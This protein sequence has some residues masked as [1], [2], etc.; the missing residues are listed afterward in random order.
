[1]YFSIP[2]EL[3]QMRIETKEFVQNELEP[4]AEEVESKNQIPQHVI[5]R[6]KEKGYFGLTI[7]KEYGGKGIGKLGI[8]LISEELAKTVFAF[9]DI[10]SINN[11][12][13]SQGLVLQGTESQKKKYLPRLAR[14]ELISAFAL[15]EPNAGSDA[16]S[17][18]TSAER[19]G[20]GFVLN[21]LKHYITNA[22]IADIFIVMAVTDSRLKARGGIT[23]FLVEKG[24][25]GLSIGS[26]HNTMG[27]RGSHQGEVVF[28]DAAVPV[29]N[30]IGKIGEGFT[31][32]MQT[33]ED[34]R[35]GVAALA[36]GMADKLFE[37][38]VEHAQK[39]LRMDKPLSASQSVQWLLA[40][41]ATE[42]FAA[43]SMLYH[44]AA[45]GDA[46]ESVQLEAVMCKVFASEV[47]GRVVDKA[48]EIF[49]SEGYSKKSVVERMCRDTRILRIFE[50]PS[51]IQRIIIGKSL[52]KGGRTN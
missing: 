16:A 20:N 11:G 41:M 22:P 17:I 8:C 1:M 44:T 32:A 28:T 21:G 46:G 45:K 37:L 40:D 35:I 18:A 6:M 31:V 43:R 48:L 14:G 13:G 36:L 51:E 49:G 5:D 38:S 30:V 34:G 23:A 47:T 2:K 24:T 3:E 19:K 33:L 9:A 12:L 50:G 10:I 42:I 4:F 39:T 29:E 15:T 26:I 52:L 25:P 27:M 7:P